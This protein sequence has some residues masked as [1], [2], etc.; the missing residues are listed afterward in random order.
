MRT[1]SSTV[2]PF[3]SAMTGA[4]PASAEPAM[5]TG[6]PLARSF[7]AKTAAAFALGSRL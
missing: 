1:A 4:S 3:D 2:W 7:F 5:V 6:N